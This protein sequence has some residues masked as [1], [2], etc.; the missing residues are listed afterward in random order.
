MF[1]FCIS[2]IGRNLSKYNPL[3][4]CH[5]E[6]SYYDL[7]SII[8]SLSMYK[9]FLFESIHLL[10]QFFE[11]QHKMLNILD[12]FILIFSSVSNKIDIYIEHN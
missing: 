4:S 6:Q 5:K 12:S 10:I 2:H 11:I 3:L 1:N 9:Y 7:N 8:D